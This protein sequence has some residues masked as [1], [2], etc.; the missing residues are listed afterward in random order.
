MRA[1]EALAAL[2]SVAAVLAPFLVRVSRAQLRRQRL[3]RE[4]ERHLRDANR[5]HPRGLT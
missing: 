4:V 1:V 3:A 2:A 5:S